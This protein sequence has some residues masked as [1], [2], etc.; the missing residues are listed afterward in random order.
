[1]KYRAIFVC[2]LGMAI[3]LGGW[4]AFAGDWTQWG[5]TD[6]RNMVSDEKSLPDSFVPGERTS[7]ASGIDLAATKNV[8]WAARLGNY[9]YGNPTVAGGRVFVG[10][11][12]RTVSS[13]PR[14][15]SGEGG[16]VKCLDEATGKLLWQL[17]V[18]KRIDLPPGVYFNHQELGTC[19]S[20][21]VEGDRVYV[22]TS[23][24]EVVCLDV[25]GQTNPTARRPS[26]ADRRPA[27]AKVIWRYDLIDELKVSPHDSASCS[28]VIHGD[29][30]YVGTSNGVDRSH[31]KIVSPEAPALVALD[32]RTGRL[33]AV[34]NEKISTRLFHCQWSSPSLGKVGDK[35]L[36]FFGGADGVCY[37]FEAL[38]N[39]PEKPVYLK[40]AWSYDCNPSSY[41]FRDGKPIHY[42]DGDRRRRLSPNKD[43]GLYV[44]PSEIIATPVFHNNRVYVAI[45]Q[46]PMHGRGRGMLHC[47][48][49]TKAGDITET[50]RIWS[51]DG[52]DRT[53]A[54]ATIADGLVYVPDI[55]GRVHCLDADSGKRYWVYETGAQIWGSILAADGKLYFGTKR[56]FVVMAAGKEAKVL[57]REQLGSAMYSTP[58]AANGVLYVASQQYL[59]AIQERREKD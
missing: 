1:M 29:V 21:T 6:G 17:V 32:K 9:A 49:A 37:A 46:D 2:C 14:T 25:H 31:E 40:K 51:Y 56:E 45:G 10:T 18:P 3:N 23:A 42:T 39:I 33:L 19:S 13:D 20:P 44:G 24:D 54:S 57:S 55:A 53:I 27:D 43:D 15:S 7:A 36:I 59:W 16:L 50:G 38:D 48:D 30:L 11:D 28:V 34:E 4:P 5:R 58:I 41:K 22:V 12:C 52:M 47:I 35:T 8:K 26:D